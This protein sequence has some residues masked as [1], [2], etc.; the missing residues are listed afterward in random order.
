MIGSLYGPA[1]VSSD[2][3]RLSTFDCSA[4]TATVIDAPA[5]RAPWVA[6]V[7]TPPRPMMATVEP[8]STV[9]C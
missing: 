5:T 9:A 6:A 1:Q 7:P 8:G 3:P 4:S 2:F